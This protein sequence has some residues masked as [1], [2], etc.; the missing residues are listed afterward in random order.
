MLVAEFLVLLAILG[1]AGIGVT[2]AAGALKGA[3]EKRV[4]HEKEMDQ[5]HADLRTAL[6]SRDHRQLDDFLV[7]WEDRLDP[8][9]AAHIKTRRDELY[10]D[11]DNQQESR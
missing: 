2:A 10:I 6:R 8:P 7:M 11:N 4:A 1:G 3:R 5:M 9:V